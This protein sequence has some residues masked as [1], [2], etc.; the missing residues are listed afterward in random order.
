VLAYLGGKRGFR[1]YAKAPAMITA[2][3]IIMAIN[4]KSRG[5]CVWF[6]GAVVPGA[7]IWDVE[8]GDDV[9]VGWMVISLPEAMGVIDCGGV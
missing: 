7:D 6:C 2:V 5:C 8:G 3:A 9:G 1:T 4:V